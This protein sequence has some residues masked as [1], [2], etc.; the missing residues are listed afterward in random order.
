MLLLMAGTVPVFSQP[1]TAVSV[2]TS[3]RSGGCSPGS[4]NERPRCYARKPRPANLNGR[5]PLCHI[6]VPTFVSAR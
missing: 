2:F 5:P 6:A 3:Q 4:R 1:T